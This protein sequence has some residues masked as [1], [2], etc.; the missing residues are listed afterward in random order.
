MKWMWRFSNPTINMAEID[1]NRLVNLALGLTDDPE[2]SEALRTSPELR[3]RFEQVAAELQ[4]LDR[5]LAKA[6]PDTDRRQLQEG[7]WRILVPFDGSHRSQRAIATAAALAA[8]CDGEIVVV[9][10]RVLE[11]PGQGPPIETRE[12]ATQLLGRIVEQLLGE[13]VRAWGVLGTA[14][15]G[16]VA[17]EIVGVATG[18]GVDLI[19]MGSHGRSNLGRLIFGSVTHKVMRRAPCPV[20]AVR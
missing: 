18:S 10:L 5:E 16:A 13:G 9:H 6:R 3:E 4:G 19:V 17:D 7:R 15:R 11:Q 2:L 20:V 14:S 12:D 8:T 1:D